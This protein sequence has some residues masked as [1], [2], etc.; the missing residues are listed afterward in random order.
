MK[1]NEIKEMLSR[2]KKEPFSIIL[3]FS[4]IILP[5]INEKWIPFFP[6]SWKKWIVIFI[7]IIWIISLFKLRKER[8]LNHRK[9]ILLNYLI[10]QK[11]HTFEHLGKEWGGKK[12]FTKENIHELVMAYPDT[13]RYLKVR[14]KGKG[15]DG[16]GLVK[17]PDEK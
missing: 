5:L 6:E 11:W 16:V 7:V 8:Q 2:F 17:N 4:L 13:F 15:K 1:D 10:K 9:K 3:L 12:E 14:R